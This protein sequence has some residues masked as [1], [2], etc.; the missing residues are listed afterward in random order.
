M[1]TV[2]IKGKKYN[3]VFGKDVVT[4]YQAGTHRIRM[5]APKNT[6]RSEVIRYM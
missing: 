4:F 2:V 3:V 1:I 5:A 6:K